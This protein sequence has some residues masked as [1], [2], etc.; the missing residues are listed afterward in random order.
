MGDALTVMSGVLRLEMEA[1][2]GWWRLEPSM[3]M[4]VLLDRSSARGRM[5]D[6]DGAE[7]DLVE[8]ETI[9]GE[10]G[11]EELDKLRQGIIKLM[12]A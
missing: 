12:L 1:D 9:W 7:M 5:G 4:R 3:K 8:A 11:G 6:T 10:A 2:V